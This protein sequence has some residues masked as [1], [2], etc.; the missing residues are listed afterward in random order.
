[1]E[2]RRRPRAREHTNTNN[3][4]VTANFSWWDVHQALSRPLSA[5]TPPPPLPRPT[6]RRPLPPQ[7]SSLARTRP[8]L[9]RHCAPPRAAKTNNAPSAGSSSR[10]RATTNLCL[11]RRTSVSRRRLSRYAGTRRQLHARA[12]LVKAHFAVCDNRQ[13]KR[14]RNARRTSRE[15]RRDEACARNARAPLHFLF[16]PKPQMVS[17]HMSQGLGVVN[18]LSSRLCVAIETN[19]NRYA[20]VLTMQQKSEQAIK[21]NPT[22]RYDTRAQQF[23]N[24][25]SKHFKNKVVFQFFFSP[26]CEKA[27]IAV[28][29]FSLISSTLIWKTKEKNQHVDIS[30][31]A[32]K[33]Q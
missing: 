9:A 22:K 29:I 20:V 7:S 16:L 18:A 10:P 30:K 15:A 13:H 23:K 31:Q 6:R 24:K 19:K 14:N 1:M 21:Y 11:R 32:N 17:P 8:A 28:T 33:Q 12:L 4:R 5:R 26:R 2:R 25:I 27:R 3:R